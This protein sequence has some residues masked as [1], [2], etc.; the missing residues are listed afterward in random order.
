MDYL[1]AFEIS[2]SGMMAEKTRVDAV[3]LNLANVNTTRAADGVLY[4]PLTVLTSPKA[5]TVFDGYF[6]SYLGQGAQPAGVDVLGVEPMDAPP[7]LV[8]EPGHPDADESG[9]VAYP[10]INP[11]AE[12]VALM[13]ALRAY[14][15]NVQAMN[16]AKTMALRALEIGGQR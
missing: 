2:A 15:A 6:S 14:E 10:G 8:Y 16:A 1:A 13:E 11:A 4:R 5:A 7:R 9:F 12:M 3:A